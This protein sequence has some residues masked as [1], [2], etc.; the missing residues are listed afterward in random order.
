MQIA[1][2]GDHPDGLAMARALVASGRHR[3]LVVCDA[4]PPE[5]A[6][7]VRVESDLEEVLADPQV[8][9]VI[10]AGP[11]NS[12]SEQL[13][14]AVQSER[15]VLCVHPCGLKPDPA[16][17]AA[18]IREDTKKALLPLLPFG[19]HPALDRFRELA[20]DF[21]LLSLEART[22]SSESTGP[23]WEVLRRIGGE[24]AEVDG[25]SAEEELNFAMPLLIQGRY[26]KTGLFQISM[27]PGGL[28]NRF[29]FTA[30]G[31]GGE[32]RLAGKSWSGPVTL[33]S[34]TDAETY[35]AWDGWTVLVSIVEAACADPTQPSRVN[36]Q[37]ELHALE[38]DDALKRSV[39]KRKAHSLEYR[40]VSE[41][42][43]SKGTM[44]LIGCGMI[45][46]ILLI[47]GISIWAPRIRWLIVPLLGGYLVLLAMQW[48]ARKPAD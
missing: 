23:N 42:I 10:V 14:R 34:A 22:T 40:Q 28:E 18:L 47:F 35:P 7:S 36:W 32:V 5:F 25:F 26:E 46:L 45:W 8:E 48:L 20:N 21:R 31:T 37:D 43:G 24:I 2:L 41:E 17:E 4:S 1:L 30:T 19:L 44:T 38:L 9:M 33:H 15:H 29:E 6:E 3:L 16:Y 39:E 13:R 12:R 27:L 11:I